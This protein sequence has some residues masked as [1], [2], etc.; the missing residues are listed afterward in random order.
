MCGIL[1]T[2]GYKVNR[3]EFEEALLKIK[4]RG[5]DDAGIWQDE[6][7]SLGHRRLSILDLSEVG[8]QPMFSRDER[9]AIVF[10]GE[11]YNYIELR[12]ELKKIGYLFKTRTDTEVALYSYLEWGEK[13]LDRFNGMWAL[14][15]YDTLQKSLFLARDRMGVKPLFLA[16]VDGGFVFSSEMKA[17]MPLLREKTINYNL[18]TDKNRTYNY[19]ASEECLVK[20]IGR[21]KAGHYAIIN[22]DGIRTV[23]WW[24]TTEHLIDVPQ[25]YEEQ[26]EYFR[27]LFKDA[28]KIRM[29]SDVALGTAL[30]GGLDS[31]ATICTMSQIC[32][33][34]REGDTDYNSDCQ[35]AFIATFP[36]TALDESEY[37]SKVT[38][39]L[40]INYT[41]IAI[42]P[43]KGLK[44]M[45][46]DLYTFEE[47]YSTSPIPMLQLYRGMK[48]HGVT[49][50]LDGHGADELFCGY[51]SDIPYALLDVGLNSNEIYDILDTYYSN[52]GESA[53]KE[54]CIKK[55]IDFLIRHC[56]KKVLHVPTWD[57]LIDKECRRDF[58]QMGH[59]ERTLYNST[60][61]TI[62]P[63]LMRNYDHY[64]MAS[65]VEIRMP[66]LDYRIVEFAFSIPWQAKLQGGYT[67]RIVRDAL[68]D[69][70]PNEVV[71]RRSKIGFNTPMIEWARGPW[72][73]W[74]LDTMSSSDFINS[75]AVDAKSLKDKMLTV[76]NSTGYSEKLSELSGFAWIELNQYLW[77]KYFFDSP[78]CKTIV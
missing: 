50:S 36:G 33:D 25:N 61:T 10:N 6:R 65:G 28:C 42:D 21:L 53:E 69:W 46:Q 74:L 55:Y 8:R 7:C 59:L 45:E 44:T 64:S 63:T 3:N 22:Q 37:A 2:F 16:K 75:D 20:E 24:K 26:V 67:K 56:A 47:V 70:I 39:Y 19:E 17:I 30:S 38:D 14:A 13:A 15:I 52:I 9:Y 57:R 32:K 11:I 72:K 40:G 77:K 66:F 5:P 31:S 29:R 23:R 58:Y 41:E 76:I 62:L 12:D 34:K 71:W 4:H 73:E 18:L 60:H 27:E 1:G 54:K 68:K 35:H 43:L 48:E 78:H 51:F 49:V